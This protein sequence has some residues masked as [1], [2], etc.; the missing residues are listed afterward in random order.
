MQH[1]INSPIMITY[2]MFDSYLADRE[3]ERE[4]EKKGIQFIEL[5]GT[6]LPSTQIGMHYVDHFRRVI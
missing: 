2:Q 1:E 3:S 5:I 4:R 6:K